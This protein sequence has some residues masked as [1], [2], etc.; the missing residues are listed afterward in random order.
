MKDELKH[1]CP[2]N[3]C[4]AMVPRHRLM[5]PTCWGLVPKP[6][7]NAVYRAY[8]AAPRSTAHYQAMSAAVE[9]ANNIS[10][11]QEP[12]QAA[13]DFTRGRHW[14]EINAEIA[15][16][17]AAFRARNSRTKTPNPLS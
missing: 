15:A 14:K 7:Q 8:R 5:C 13:N 16:N 10:N 4:E 11:G 3:G 17:R 2:V 9:A 6:I 12:H 1:R